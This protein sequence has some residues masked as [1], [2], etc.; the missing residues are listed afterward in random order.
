MIITCTL[1]L[2]YTAFF[3]AGLLV[4]TAV[5]WFLHSLFRLGG[6]DEDI[7]RLP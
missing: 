5:G 2:K 1:C 3:V 6:G 7:F 4:G